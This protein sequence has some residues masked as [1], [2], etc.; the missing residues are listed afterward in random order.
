MPVIHEETSGHVEYWII[1]AV[2]GPVVLVAALFVLFLWRWKR[3]GPAKKI[4]PQLPVKD[5]EMVK[6]PP[7]VCFSV[8]L[9]LSFYH[10][11][12]FLMMEISTYF[13]N[14]SMSIGYCLR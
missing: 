8:V 3:G 7:H 6:Q 1:G 2:I 10:F 14:A 4:S 5:V 9:L 11:V 13:Y 12:D